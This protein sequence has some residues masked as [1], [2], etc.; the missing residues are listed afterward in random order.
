MEAVTLPAHT[1]AN[2]RQLVLAN[3]PPPVN[4]PA[5]AHTPLGPNRRTPA[6]VAT[7]TAS[8]ASP[9]TLPEG[10]GGSEPG[11]NTSAHR[12][13]NEAM[14]TARARNRRNQP[15]TVAAGNPSV[16]AIVR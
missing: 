8:T 16:A 2:Q 1:G 9:T 13:K 7:P 4:R 15:R 10:R 11:A 12:V 6:R 5:N 14:L 3:K